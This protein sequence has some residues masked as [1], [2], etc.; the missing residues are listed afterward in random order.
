MQSTICNPQSTMP[1]SRRQQKSTQCDRVRRTTTKTRART[2]ARDAQCSL[3]VQE[4]SVPASTPVI[5]AP[6]HVIPAKAGIPSLG[7]DC[8]QL[9]AD[10]THRWERIPQTEHRPAIPKVCQRSRIRSESQWQTRGAIAERLAPCYYE[11]P[12][13]LAT[14]HT[15]SMEVRT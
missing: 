6:S 10:W 9:T 5:P 15:L 3:L 13:S 11:L 1:S 12:M 4:H 2:H 14:S 8:T 7:M